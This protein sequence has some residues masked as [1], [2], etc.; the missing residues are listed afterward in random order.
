MDTEKH[1]HSDHIAVLL[2]QTDL[3]VLTKL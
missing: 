1:I 3:Q 2:L